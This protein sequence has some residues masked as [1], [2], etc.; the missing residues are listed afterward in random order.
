MGI[1]ITNK[2]V[3]KPMEVSEV[4]PTDGL[5]GYWPLNGDT[6][7][8]SGNGNDGVNNGATITSGN[9]GKLA[10]EFDGVDDYIDCVDIS[11]PNTLSLSLWVNPNTTNTT[12]DG[13]CFFGKN[14][15]SGGNIFLFGY[16]YN[17]YNITLNG[18]TQLLAVGQQTSGTWNHL[19]LVV[20]DKGNS[21]VDL[22]LYR[23]SVLLESKNLAKTITDSAGTTQ[24]GM[25][26]DG[27]SKTDFFDGKIQ[28]VRIYNRALSPEEVKIL[29]DMTAGDKI[30]MK[31]TADTLYVNQL[32]EV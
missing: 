12:S 17:G 4:G 30:K 22:S 15:S 32:N 26:Y 25:E 6:L 5:V 13:Q 19:V 20:E 7:D 14:T 10:Y 3:Y 27:S 21:T 31:Q 11:I 2:G 29:Y 16:W 18:N 24:I 8:Y 1:G 28:D 9:N 23:N